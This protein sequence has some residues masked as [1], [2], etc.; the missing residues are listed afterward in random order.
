[1]KFTKALTGMVLAIFGLQLGSVAFAQTRQQSAE[2][3]RAAE[4]AQALKEATKLVPQFGMPCEIVEAQSLGQVEATKDGKTVAA[5]TYEVACKNQQGFLIMENKGNAFG[6]PIDCLQ[7]QTL[8]KQNPG[9]MVCKLKA[10]RTS[11]Y[12]LGPIA[13][14]K[15][16][17]CAIASARWIGPNV[18]KDKELYEI[19]CKNAPGGIFTVP[20]HKSKDQS[21]EF[22]NCL[23]VEGTSLKCESTAHETAVQYLSP[24]VKK[25][26]TGCAM[27]N[28]RFVGATKEAEYY[29]IGCG[30]K[31]GFIM[32]TDLDAQYKATVGCDKAASIGG[33]QFTDVSALKAKQQADMDAGKA[34]FE[35]AL[36]KGG[37]S[38]T[39]EN[40]AKLG[41][42]SD[43]KRELVEFKCTQMPLGLIALIPAEGATSTFESYDCFAAKTLEV[44]CKFVS[45]NDMI[46]HLKGL[47]AG[48]KSI[49]QACVIDK[50]RYA[51]T[52]GKGEIVMEIGCDNK[53]G[54]ITVLNKARTALNPVVPCHI[55]AT[56][57]NVPEKC[58]IAGN[59]SN[60]GV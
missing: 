8:N 22:L 48:H 24:Q 26:G 29:E 57:P 58:T 46:A 42:Q 36:T 25:S 19:A 39:I 5:T 10:N 35:A 7:A 3:A 59:G 2:R 49:P 21:V 23:K 60:K 53:M 31:P 52:G 16:P 40:Y 17:N 28:A 27:S 1:M 12:W 13:Q 30:E 37:V 47:A 6:D 45:E 43:T 44:P 55:A 32:V 38:C 33:C 56:N 4:Q 51:F 41:Y 50:A 34:K 14:T 54:Y 9:A 15:I 18:S 11:H 20:T